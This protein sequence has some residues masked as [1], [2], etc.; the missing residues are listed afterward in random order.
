[1]LLEGGDRVLPPFKARLSEYA[2][3][4][5]VR[6]GVAPWF[7]LDEGGAIASEAFPG[8]AAPIGAVG[9]TG[10]TSDNDEACA[11][12]AIGAVGLKAKN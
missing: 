2:R 10:D 7:V 9:V 1:M 5:L 4:Q 8:V 6:R 12:A 3:R 11:L